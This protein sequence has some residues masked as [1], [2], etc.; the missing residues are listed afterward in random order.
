MK[1]V[2][3]LVVLSVF[4]FAGAGLSAA[5]YQVIRLYRP[6]Q[7]AVAPDRIVEIPRGTSVSGAARILY[8]RGL[9]PS[10][11]GFKLLARFT[12]SEGVIRAGEYGI[13]PGLT[14]REILTLLRKGDVILHRVTIPEGLRGEEVAVLAAQTLGLSAERMAA[15][16]KDPEF[17]RSLGVTA[18]TLEGYLLPETYS[19]PRKVTEEQVI[20]K[21]VH[22]ML[23]FIDEEKRKEAEALGL[24]LHGLLTLASIIEKEMGDATEAPVI[25]SVYHNRLKK[26][27]LLQ[28]DPTVIYGIK[29]F[30]GD[31]RWKDLRTDTPYNTYVRKGLPPTPIANPGRQA[32]LGALHPAETNYL[33]FVSRNNGTHVFSETLAEHNRSVDRFQKKRKSRK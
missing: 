12:Q 24:S 23:A 13:S 5:G 16:I 33:F 11:L 30:D 15:L 4:L 10:V 25:A 27:M 29:D 32:I 20:G 31:I 2:R 6:L 17:I 22:D 14:S 19:F 26:G 7:A 3:L 9:I 28:S 21:A 18:P 8:D 1:R